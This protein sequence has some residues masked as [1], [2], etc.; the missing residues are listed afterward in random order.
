[1][2][3]DSDVPAA[4]LKITFIS[5]AVTYFLTSGSV[6]TIIANLPVLGSKLEQLSHWRSEYVVITK[7][8]RTGPVTIL[9]SGDKGATVDLRLDPR[10][11]AGSLPLT[12]AEGRF[13]IARNSSLA[14][15]VTVD[16][17][18]TPPFHA[19]RLRRPLARKPRPRWRT[20]G[21]VGDSSLTSVNWDKFT[22]LA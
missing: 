8:L 12:I 19:M 21:P 10:A 17:E 6:L 11:L 16:G 7:R 4:A 22:T 5:G 14:A 9:V 3:V 18:A 2:V 15:R 1:V 20:T 13:A